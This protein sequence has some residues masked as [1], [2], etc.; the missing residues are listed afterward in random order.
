MA[1]LGLKSGFGGFKAPAPSIRPYCHPHL[2][3]LY[4]SHCPQDRSQS[5]QLSSQGLPPWYVPSFISFFPHSLQPSESSSKV[6]LSSSPDPYLKFIP[7]LWRLPKHFIWASILKACIDPL[8]SWLC[9]PRSPSLRARTHFYKPLYAPSHPRQ[10]P[11]KSGLKTSLV[12]WTHPGSPRFLSIPLQDPFHG[13]WALSQPARALYL[14]VLLCLS[15]LQSHCPSSSASYR[16]LSTTGPLLCLQCPSCL[17][18][19]VNFFSFRSRL[20]SLHLGSFP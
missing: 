14:S 4:G 5:L 1:E 6:T 16:A 3:F 10:S 7:P 18:C 2:K 8:L 12:N 13:P 19:P 15:P 9:L 17:S 20:M 11:A